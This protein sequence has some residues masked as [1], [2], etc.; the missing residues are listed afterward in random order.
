[1][2]VDRL[3]VGTSSIP[4]TYFD[5]DTSTAQR[6]LHRD[7]SN[8][9]YYIA[10]G[11]TRPLYFY[12]NSCISLGGGNS[13]FGSASRVMFIYDVAS[14]PSSSGSNCM[15]LFN[16]T[17][18]SVF[19]IGARTTDNK[20]SIFDAARECA[21]ITRTL[22]IASA[23][24]TNLDTSSW[25]VAFANGVNGTTTGLLS[26]SDDCFVTMSVAASWQSN[27]VGHRQLSVMRKTGA[28]YTTVGSV[29][30]MAVSG[31]TT[32]QEVKFF[33][34]LVSGTDALT[35]QVYQNS[36]ESLDVSITVSVVRYETH[37]V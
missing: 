29:S 1:V 16:A 18:A 21:T 30:T 25:T 23:L 36:S 13:V 5:Y 12:K 33:G 14:V 35:V 10:F 3:Y 8:L 9:A 15:I 31:E 28:V 22:T 26:F 24:A 34:T 17:S 20:L 2:T 4:T 6:G 11:S 7:T 32:T 37:E 27:S 19:G